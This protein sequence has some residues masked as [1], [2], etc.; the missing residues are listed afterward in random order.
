MIPAFPMDGGRVFRAFLAFFVPRLQAT[1]VAVIVGI[2][3]AGFFAF[4]GIWQAAPLWLLISVFV[5]LAGLMELAMLQKQAQ[6]RRQ[7]EAERSQRVVEEWDAP[8]QLSPPE[9]NFSGYTWDS[10]FRVWIEWRGGWPVR[11]CRMRGL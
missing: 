8:G 1:K 3:F 7:E 10:R 5:P 4:V 6:M 11:S 2:V 9:P